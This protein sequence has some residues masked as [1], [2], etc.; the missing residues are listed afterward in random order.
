MDII[1][2]T[3]C[4]TDN[5]KKK[6]LIKKILIISTDLVAVCPQSRIGTATSGSSSIFHHTWNVKN[7]I[8]YK[9]NEIV[10]EKIFNATGNGENTIF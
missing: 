4:T 8:N 6:K 7:D 10:G 5:I 2:C 3:K 9:Y 1:K